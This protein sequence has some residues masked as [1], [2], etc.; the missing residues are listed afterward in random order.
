MKKFFGALAISL[1]LLT[2][3][4]GFANISIKI[5][6]CLLYCGEKYDDGAFWACVD[7]CLHG[8]GIDLNNAVNHAN[9]TPV[10]VQ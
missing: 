8:A 2:G 10:S 1:V 7:G 3:V 6:D 9:L 5:E 4:V